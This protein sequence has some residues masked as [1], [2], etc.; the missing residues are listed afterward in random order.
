MRELHIFGHKTKKVEWKRGVSMAKK[1]NPL[2]FT[3]GQC[4]KQAGFMHFNFVVVELTE[5]ELFLGISL[6]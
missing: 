1:S 2:L 3:H 4:G 5:G 6:H